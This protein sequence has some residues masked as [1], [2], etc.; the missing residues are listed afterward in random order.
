M[1]PFS[2]R[3]ATL[4]WK[5]LDNKQ[6][7]NTIDIILFIIITTCLYFDQQK[8]SQKRKQIILIVLYMLYMFLYPL[9]WYFDIS[10]ILIS[11]SKMILKRKST[12][13][14][15]FSRS[16]LSWFV[17][18]HSD[19]ASITL[20]I[21]LIHVCIVWFVRVGDNITTCITLYL[22]KY[23][24]ILLKKIERLFKALKST[25]R[26]RICLEKSSAILFLDA[27][28]SLDSKLWVSQ[29]VSHWC[30]SDFQ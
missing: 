15:T 5:K 7:Q 6:N 19:V 30:F 16:P 17:F 20:M 10:D 22:F 1:D 4:A 12:Q 18:T 3:L 23:I 9:F 21:L 28:A 26:S 29:W 25:A 8:D 13:S 14:I 11:L 27:L 2:E 24:D